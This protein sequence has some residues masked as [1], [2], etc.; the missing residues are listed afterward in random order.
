MCT[1]RRNPTT[2]QVDTV[3]WEAIFTGSQQQ[4]LATTIKDTL[5]AE[6]PQEIFGNSRVIRI[7]NML[8]FFMDYETSKA[9]LDLQALNLTWS[10]D[11]LNPNSFL[12]QQYA[13]RICGDVSIHV[14]RL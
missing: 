12:Y 4:G 8:I 2:G 13:S 11:L 10:N 14:F 6:L 5:F 3:N 9:T 7:G 1:F